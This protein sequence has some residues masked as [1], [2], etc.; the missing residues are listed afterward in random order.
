MAASYD[1]SP[2]TL[3]SSTSELALRH[4]RLWLVAAVFLAAL[5]TLCDEFLPTDLASTAGNFAVWIINFFLSYRISEAVLKEEGLLEVGVRLYG[6][7]FLATMV[8]TLAIGFGFVLLF[9]PGLYLMARWSMAVPLII[10][11]GLSSGDAISRSWEQTGRCVWSIIP[12]YV[13]YSLAVVA[14]MGAAAFFVFVLET[15]PGLGT[16][17]SLAFSTRFNLA[18]YVLEFVGSLIGIAVYRSISGD[19]RTARDVFA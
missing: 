14:A 1:I 19:S 7:M 3:F 15:E 11:K 8:T 18:S 2:T 12:I 9:V 5:Q 13:V 17:A 16:P 10:A 4:A 6:T